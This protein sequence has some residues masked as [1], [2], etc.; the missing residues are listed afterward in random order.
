MGYECYVSSTGII[1]LVETYGKN[2][3]HSH[4]TPDRTEISRPTQ[5]LD[6]GNPVLLKVLPNAQL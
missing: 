1:P 6:W 4:S 5:A 3:R 2:R